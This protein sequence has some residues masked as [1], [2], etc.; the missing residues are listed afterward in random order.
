MLKRSILMLFGAALLASSAQAATLS[1]SGPVSVNRGNGFQPV[2]G[3]VTVNP[4]DR[5]L[6]G[7]GGSASI[8]Y[9]ASCVTS[10]APNRMAV[11][12][13]TAPC[14]TTTTTELTPAGN[15]GLIVGG[16]L[17]AGGVAAAVIVSNNKSNG[18]SP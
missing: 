10:V 4:G 15:T 13:G 7:N 9:T 3:T 5:V 16:A 1:A 12:R 6:V 2:S 8:S 17:L 14:T 11:V 18:A